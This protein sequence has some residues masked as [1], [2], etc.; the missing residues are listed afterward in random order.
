MR[1]RTAGCAAG[2]NIDR[3]NDFA[4][5]FDILAE[6]TDIGHRVIAAAGG[7]S[8]PVHAQRLRLAQFC[9]DEAGGFQRPSFGFDQSKVAVVHARATDEAAHDT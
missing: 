2:K 8:R 4:V 9:F 7:T 3:F 1:R 6:Q 5:D